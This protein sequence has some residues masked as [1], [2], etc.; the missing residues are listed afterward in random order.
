LRLREDLEA[1]LGRM[2][3]YGICCCVALCDIESFKAYNDSYGH[4]AGDEVL[5]KVAGTI[6]SHCRGGDTAYRYGGMNSCSFF[7]G[8]ALLRPSSPLIGCGEV[9][10]LW[11][12]STR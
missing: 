10:K 2:E 12:S 8:R 6:S 3:R 4:L 9:S 5:R 11:L 7:R 1:S